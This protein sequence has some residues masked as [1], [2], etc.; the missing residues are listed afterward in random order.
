MAHEQHR[1]CIDACNSC[2]DSCDH[3]AAACLQEQDVAAMARCIRL[4]ID[5]AQICRLASGAMARGSDLAPQICGFCAEICDACAEECA[6]HAHD[7]CKACAEAC[8][9]CAQACR[10]MAGAAK[11][12]ARKPQTTGFPAH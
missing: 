2:A 6:R 9:R 7:H 10:R 5:C 11:G 8:R 4:D 1:D 3:C 12:A